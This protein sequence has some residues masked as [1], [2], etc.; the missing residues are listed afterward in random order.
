[1][2]SILRDD[3]GYLNSRHYAM[4]LIQYPNGNYKTNDIDFVSFENE[5]FLFGECKQF[6]KGKNEIWIDNTKLNMLE[7]LRKQYIICCS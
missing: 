1:M 3:I 6:V 7:Q 5:R 2:A 4:S